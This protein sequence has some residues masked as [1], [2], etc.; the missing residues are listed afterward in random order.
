[1]AHIRTFTKRMIIDAIVLFMLILVLLG[2]TLIQGHRS[3]RKQK[4]LR[5]LSHID[6]N[7]KWYTVVSYVG[8]M[9]LILIYLVHLVFKGENPTDVISLKK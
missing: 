7:K 1:M 6:L 3:V 5:Q 2:L 4:L 9:N 8:L